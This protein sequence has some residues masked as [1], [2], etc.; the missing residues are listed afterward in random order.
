MGIKP[1]NIVKATAGR[2]KDRFFVVLSVDSGYAAIADGKTRRVQSPK[3][4]SLKHLAETNQQI[5]VNDAT[6]NNS[7]KRIL[8]HLNV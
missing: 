4:K 1:G 6:T 8:S 5:S 2:D 7:I 3:R